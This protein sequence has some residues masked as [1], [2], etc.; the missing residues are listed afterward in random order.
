MQGILMQVMLSAGLITKIVCFF[1]NPALEA[2]FLFYF[3]RD[4]LFINILLLSS[5]AEAVFK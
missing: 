4:L 1:E 5:R 2:G 3:F